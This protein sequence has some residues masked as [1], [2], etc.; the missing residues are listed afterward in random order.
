MSRTRWYFAGFICCE[1]AW[2]LLC[3]FGLVN[4]Q[5][6]TCH[7]LLKMNA[8]VTHGW[9]CAGTSL[10]LTTVEI[11]VVYREG[12]PRI[13]YYGSS[14]WGL[15]LAAQHYR[16]TLSFIHILQV[17]RSILY[18]SSPDFALALTLY[19]R[20]YRPSPQTLLFPVTFMSSR[21]ATKTGSRIVIS[22]SALLWSRGGISMLCC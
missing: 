21:Y 22:Q 4:C 12:Q 16:V 20:D 5:S 8:E 3:I 15:H 18:S 9:T 11:V 2:E 19:C 1:Y 17:I 10:V 13:D 6:V 7:H 14:R